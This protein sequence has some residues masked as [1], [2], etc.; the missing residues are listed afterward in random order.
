MYQEMAPRRP[1]QSACIPRLPFASLAPPLS[2][3]SRP[4]YN[5]ETAAPS[6][7]TGGAFSRRITPR[8][9]RPSPIDWVRPGPL[10]GPRPPCRHQ[11]DETGHRPRLMLSRCH[12]ARPRQGRRCTVSIVAAYRYL[13]A[14][15]NT[16]PAMTSGMP[17]TNSSTLSR[18]HCAAISLDT[19]ASSALSN[20]RMLIS[21]SGPPSSR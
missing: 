12:V 5:P 18:I 14:A 2:S 3:S 17:F 20:T 9:G 6:P 7:P 1:D 4:D 11:I 19:S 15:T 10:H 16:S 21:T 13:F 8:C